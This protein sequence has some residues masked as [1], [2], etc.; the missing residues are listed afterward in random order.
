MCAVHRDLWSMIMCVISEFNSQT[1]HTI[2]WLI[3]N[4]LMINLSYNAA[5]IILIRLLYDSHLSS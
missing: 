1:R 3:T 2:L 4:F 5:L